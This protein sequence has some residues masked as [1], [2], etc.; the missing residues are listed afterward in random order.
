MPSPYDAM[1]HFRRVGVTRDY[2]VQPFMT[3]DSTDPA[4]GYRYEMAAR[5]ADSCSP[6]GTKRGRRR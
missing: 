6:G 1:P 3:V 2:T 4:P 5:T